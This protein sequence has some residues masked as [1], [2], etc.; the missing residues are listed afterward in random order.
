MTYAERG[1]REGKGVWG[2]KGCM[3]YVCMKEGGGKQNKGW[4]CERGGGG[5]DDRGTFDNW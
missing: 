3:L 4:V 2:R 1:G 5:K